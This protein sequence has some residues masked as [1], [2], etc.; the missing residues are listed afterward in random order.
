LNTF[1]TTFAFCTAFA[2]R[3][4]GGEIISPAEVENAY[5]N[6]PSVQSVAAITVPHDT[7]QV[8]GEKDVWNAGVEM[9]NK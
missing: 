9:L 2:F 7:L 6:H 1:R 8:C 3:T 4:A 5:N